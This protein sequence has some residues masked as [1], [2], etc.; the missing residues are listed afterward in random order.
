MNNWE[1]RQMAISGI[2]GVLTALIILLFV[3]WFAPAQA[4]S[5]EVCVMRANFFGQVLE[6]KA[7]GDS[8]DDT[9][10]LIRK[11]EPNHPE[12]ELMV[13]ATREAYAWEGSMLEGISQYYESC[14]SKEEL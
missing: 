11:Y 7:M 8:L 12:L 14:L 9:I 13:Q 5:P 6:V 3:Y 1:S 4:K 2:A 10:A